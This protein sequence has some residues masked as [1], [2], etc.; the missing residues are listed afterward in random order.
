[1]VLKQG[2]GR[3][4]QQRWGAAPEMRKGTGTMETLGTWGK[5]EATE[6]D[7][8]GLA[9]WY[10]GRLVGFHLSVAKAM[11]IVNRLAGETVWSA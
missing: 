6:D 9:V 8:L 2:N 11:E 7:T 4:R 3:E 10:N 5:I 1:V